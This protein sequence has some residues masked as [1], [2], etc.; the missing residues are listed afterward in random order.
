MDNNWFKIERSILSGDVWNQ[1]F[2]K[3]EAYLYLAMNARWQKKP[4]EIRG[5]IVNT[6]QFV[7]TYRELSKVWRWGLG[8]VSRFCEELKNKG[9]LIISNY[10]NA[11]LITITNMAP[12]GILKQVWNANGTQNG[13]QNGTPF[14]TQN[15]TPNTHNNNSLDEVC[16]TQNGTHFGTLFGTQNGTIL[17]R[18]DDSSRPQVINDSKTIQVNNTNLYTNITS[19]KKKE[20]Y[21]PLTPKGRPAPKG[22]ENY[23]FSFVDE[24]FYDV[25]VRWLDYRRDEKKPRFIY[26]KQRTL[27]DCYQALL[28]TSRNDPAAAMEIVQYSIACGYQGIFTPKG[29]WYDWEQRKKAGDVFNS[30]ITEEQDVL[31]AKAYAEIDPNEEAALY[32]VDAFEF[33]TMPK[34]AKDHCREIFKGK[35]LKWIGEHQDV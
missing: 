23:D 12:E 31:L 28:K 10:K 8:S 19:V 21:N 17:E 22:Y 13:T 25:F 33:A 30:A 9:V 6:G 32:G 2:S 26:A 1:K 27:Q 11:T 3:A 29:F 14:G 35:M 34:V 7:T 5:I 18:T 24:A 16:G 20:E 4:E 15:G